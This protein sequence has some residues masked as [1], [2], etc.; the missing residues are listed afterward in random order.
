MEIR[1]NWKKAFRIWWACQCYWFMALFLMTGFY[2]IVLAVLAPFKNY[3]AYTSLHVE[4]FIMLTMLLCI[5]LAL[6][7]AFKMT[8]GKNFGDFRIA[9]VNKSAAGRSEN[10]GPAV[11]PKTST[12]KGPAGRQPQ[13]PPQPAHCDPATDEPEADQ[14]QDLRANP[15]FAEGLQTF[16]EGL[17]QLPEAHGR[18]GYDQTNPIPVNGVTGER[19][20]LNRLVSK[21][22]AGFL[23]HR[24]GSMTSPV[25]P[26]PIDAFELLAVDGSQHI[27]FY[28][29]PYHPRRSRQEPSEL[30]LIPWGNLNQTERVMVKLDFMGSTLCLEDFPFSLPEA[31]ASDRALNSISAEFACGMAGRVRAALQTLLKAM[32][33][34][35]SK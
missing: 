2:G 7:V 28:F 31:I 29:S 21:S 5:P 34:S 8:L 20:Y 16:P 15:V 10:K 13:K 30:R 4:A 14:L 3:P 18:F 17:E 12:P 11:S 27:V 19:V 33:G 24:L 26:Y 9:L 35:D 25:S 32:P 23:Y 22:G 1:A 6:V